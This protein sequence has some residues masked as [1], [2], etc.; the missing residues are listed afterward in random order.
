MDDFEF[1][2]DFARANGIC[3]KG[4]LGLLLC[5]TRNFAEGGI[6]QHDDDLLTARGGQ[7]KGISG[8]KVRKILEE[9]GI[10]RALSSEAG[11]TS[12][13]SVDTAKNYVRL[14]RDQGEVDLKK[15]ED[16]WVKRVQLFFDREPFVLRYD[17]SKSFRTIVRDLLDQ[18]IERQARDGNDVLRDRSRAPDWGEARVDPQRADN[19]SLGVHRRRERA[20]DGDF[21][22]GNVVV[23]VTTYPSKNLIEKCKRNLQTG[24]RPLIITTHKSVVYTDQLCDEGGIGGRVEVFEAEQFLVSNFYEHG[25]FETS[26]CRITSRKSSNGITRSLMRWKRI[27]RSGLRVHRHFLGFRQKVTAIAYRCRARRWQAW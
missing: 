26:G 17:A 15:V 8:D 23:H 25:R 20:R 22:V 19:T 9:H 13:G 10:E 14:L 16:W 18:A 1:L 11:R 2:H 3:T 21:V 6:P 12:R 27:R 24:M 5:L 7:V 4:A